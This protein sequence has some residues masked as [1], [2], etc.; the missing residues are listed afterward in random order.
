MQTYAPPSLNGQS[1]ADAQAQVQRRCLTA[2][3]GAGLPDPLPITAGRIHFIRQVDAAGTI[4]LL[5]E[6]WQVGVRYTGRYVWATV[7][8]QA[9]RLT[10]YYRAR[11]N[12]PVRV[13]RHCPYPLGETVLPLQ[14]HFRRPY[15]RCR[16]S[17][18]L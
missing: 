15:P 7:N 17:T 12:R 9:R 13:L 3:E 4:T 11:A 2:S 18:M 6:V 14:P 16:V 10:L 8:T 5:N 1:P